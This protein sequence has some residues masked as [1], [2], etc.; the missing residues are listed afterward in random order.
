MACWEPGMLQVQGLSC[1]GRNQWGPHP[2]PS[3]SSMTATRSPGQ[4]GSMTTT[5]SVVVAGRDTVE[6][7]RNRG[8]V[9]CSSPGQST[10][11]EHEAALRRR[12]TLSSLTCGPDTRPWRALACPTMRRRSV[13]ARRS[14]PGHGSFRRGPP[15][16][17]RDARRS[18][19]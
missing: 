2:V 1:S 14:P 15:C 8:G 16:G 19:S 6:P 5:A 7:I 11:I 4:A 17:S 12:M 13:V 3:R 9:K 10:S 18:A